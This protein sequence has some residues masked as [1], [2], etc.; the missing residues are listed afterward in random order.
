[1]DL[2]C[3][4]QPC[5]YCKHL[6]QL[7]MQHATLGYELPA[8]EGGSFHPLCESC[9]ATYHLPKESPGDHAQP[10]L[11]VSCISDDTCKEQAA[12]PRHCSILDIKCSMDFSTHVFI[13]VC[14]GDEQDYVYPYITCRLR[15]LDSQEC[16]ECFLSPKLVLM[17]PLPFAVRDTAAQAKIEELRDGPIEAIL[18]QSFSLPSS[19]EAKRIVLSYGHD[20]N[21]S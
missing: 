5:W 21:T 14:T 10:K 15:E 1:M 2:K 11:S 8:Q 9:W 17:G 6:C 20:Q 3:R 12:F 16:I 13:S 4:A 7:C 19:S 18:Q